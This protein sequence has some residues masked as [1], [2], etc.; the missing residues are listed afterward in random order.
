MADRRRDGE[1]SGI[2]SRRRKGDVTS[3]IEKDRK[4]TTGRD[5]K[6]G[7]DGL[8]HSGRVPVGVGQ[9]I[10]KNQNLKM[11]PPPEAPSAGSYFRSSL[12]AP[13]R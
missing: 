9:S 12:P 10:A 2:G 5:L 6:T 4:V 11:G 13:A 1:T 8:V 7:F 3:R